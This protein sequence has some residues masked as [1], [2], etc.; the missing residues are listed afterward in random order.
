MGLMGC[1]EMRGQ[2]QCKIGLHVRDRL[3]GDVKGRL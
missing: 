1:S 3:D 2:L